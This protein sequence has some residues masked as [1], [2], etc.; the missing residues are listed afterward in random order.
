M[1]SYKCLISNHMSISHRLGDICT[2]PLG[3]P[4]LIIS[5]DHVD[6]V[7]EPQCTFWKLVRVPESHSLPLVVSKRRKTNVFPVNTFYFGVIYVFFGLI[8]CTVLDYNFET[9]FC[10]LILKNEVSTIFSFSLTWNPIK[11]KISNS[12]QRFSNLPW[13]SP[14]MVLL[15]WF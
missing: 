10:C 11:V 9:H 1:S 4:G 14:A 3:C 6:V 8:W 2:C 7:L 15:W 12:G 5:T 13:I